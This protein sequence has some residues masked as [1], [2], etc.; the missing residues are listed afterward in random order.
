MHDSVP[1]PA[2]RS[3]RELLESLVDDAASFHNVPV[4]V[5]RDAASITARR[6]TTEGTKPLG[7]AM[8]SRVT[9]YCWGVIR[10]R[11]IRSREPALEELRGHYLLSSVVEDLRG[12]GHSAHDIFREIEESFATC[13]SPE[14][15]ASFRTRLCG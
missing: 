4:S 5:A 10:R 13:V 9:A 14:T 12:S 2:P 1:A 8:A 15:L 7:R 6:F 3:L 11:S